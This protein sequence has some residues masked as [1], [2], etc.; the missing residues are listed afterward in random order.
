MMIPKLPEDALLDATHEEILTALF[1]NL[2]VQQANMAFAMLGVPLPDG[3]VNH[4][5]DIESA[6][7]VIDQLEML[8]DK[9]KGNLSE[10][11][12]RLLTDT[13][14]ALKKTLLSKFPD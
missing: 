6:K 13:L 4:D 2:V 9:T 14:T 5:P 3:S 11:E 8:A 10:E 1:N 7:L 12:T